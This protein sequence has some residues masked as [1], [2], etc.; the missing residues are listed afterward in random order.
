[1]ANERSDFPL[2]RSYRDQVAWQQLQQ[3]FSADYQLN[4]HNQPTEYYWAWREQHHIHIDYY[5]QATAAAKIILVHGVGSNGRQ[6]S[7]ILGRPLAEAGYECLALD[8]P[9]YGLSESRTKSI[10]YQDWVAVLDDF[11]R[12]QQQKDDRPIFLFGLSAGGMLCLHVAARN[13]QIKGIIA[14]TLLDQRYAVVNRGT[15]RFSALSRINLALLGLLAKTPLRQMLL[16]MRW[17]SKMDKLCNHRLACQSMLNDSSSAG[18]AMSI[19]FLDSYM[20]YQ[21]EQALQDITGPALLLTQPACDRWTDLSLS[22]PVLQQLSLDY[23]V[24]L[25]PQGGHYPIEASALNALKQHSLR[26]IAAQ[27]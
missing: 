2:R 19:G 17:V 1:M 27:L 21:P 14:M 23:Q 9:A 3:Y 5:P 22:E 16:P 20:H 26:F 8:L 13:P 25:L 11:I 24:V 7:L 10:L 4:A 6:M 15:M 18:N 12:A